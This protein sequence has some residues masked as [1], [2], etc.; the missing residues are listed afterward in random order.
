M[1]VKG[2]LKLNC[3]K[4]IF[5]ECL[6]RTHEEFDICPVEKAKQEYCE[7]KTEKDVNK[8]RKYTK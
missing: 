6:K 3:K 2:V 4:C 8:T 5:T 1:N 7:T